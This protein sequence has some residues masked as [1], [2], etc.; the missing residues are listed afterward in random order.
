MENTE[1][2]NWLKSEIDMLNE[3]LSESSLNESDEA[4]ARL[5]NS[6]KAW[7]AKAT[8]VLSRPRDSEITSEEQKKLEM[9]RRMIEVLKFA[10]W[11]KL[12]NDLYSN[13][14]AE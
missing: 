9:Q 13:E 12:L 2:L 4:E 3:F 1:M 6:I 5:I 8:E 7:I 10:C 14:E 11:C